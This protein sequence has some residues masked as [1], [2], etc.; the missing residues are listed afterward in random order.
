MQFHRTDT[1]GKDL[2]R[3]IDFTD[4]DIDIHNPTVD[5]IEFVHEIYFSLCTQRGRRLK[6]GFDISKWE[7]KIV[8]ILCES[9]NS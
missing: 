2:T 4:G 8:Q 5:E 9:G 3:I 7:I 1:K 6:V